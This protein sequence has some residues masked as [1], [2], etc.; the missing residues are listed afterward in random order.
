MIAK[1]KAKRKKAGKK[2]IDKKDFKINLPDN[3]KKVELGPIKDKWI[4]ALKSGRYEQ[5]AGRL[6]TESGGYCCLGVLSKIQKRLTSSCD[7]SFNA[8]T[9][10][11][12][13]LGKL[14]NSFRSTCFIE[15]DNPLIDVLQRNGVFPKGVSVELMTPTNTAKRL[16]DCTCS[17][18]SSLTECNDEGMSFKQ[19][20]EIIDTI[21]S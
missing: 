8:P 4:K 3:Y 2:V 21:W 16:N 13:G 9:T 7:S 15:S 19:I 20:A 11:F 5:G 17:T 10:Y 14:N 12:D 1:I 18:C 6:R